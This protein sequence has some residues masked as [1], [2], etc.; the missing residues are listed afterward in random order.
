VKLN[1]GTGEDNGEFVPHR[2]LHTRGHPRSRRRAHRR[3]P[4]T[5]R[6]LS[7][8]THQPCAD[9]VFQSSWELRRRIS[10]VIDSGTCDLRVRRDSVSLGSPLLVVVKAAHQRGS[11]GFVTKSQASANGVAPPR[12]RQPPPGQRHHG[13]AQAAAWQRHQS[14]TRSGP[15]P[16]R[17]S[18]QPHGHHSFHRYHWRRPRSASIGEASNSRGSNRLHVD[19]YPRQSSDPR[20][21]PRRPVVYGSEST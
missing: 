20:R 11:Q 6:T 15:R 12:L 7:L 3:T 13:P 1:P 16:G 18:S 8:R 17:G 2:H 14:T 9:F 10:S 19:S 4:P 5:R 21:L